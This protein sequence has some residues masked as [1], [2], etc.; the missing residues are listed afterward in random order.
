[1]IISSRLSEANF[2]SLVLDIVETFLLDMLTEEVFEND[3]EFINN[4]IK[5][6][7][8]SVQSPKTD[9]VKIHDSFRKAISKIKTEDENIEDLKEFGKTGL[10]FKDSKIIINFINENIKSVKEYIENQSIDSF[11]GI[12]IKLI[13]EKHLNALDDYKFS[14]LVSET[15]SWNQYQNIILA[16]MNNKHIEEIK[17]IW[18]TEITSD[19]DNFYILLAKGFYYLLPWI[20]S[21]LILLTA[22]I[23][24][25]D[26]FEISENIR[27]IPT[28]M[29]YGLNN[30]VACIARGCGIKT[31]ETAL[32]LAKQ[33]NKT[34]HIEF[35]SWLANLQKQ[36]I[37]VM[38]LSSFEKENIIDIV[39]S[40]AP[41]SNKND[42]THFSFDIVGTKYK[43][44]WKKTSLHIRNSDTLE[45][46]RDKENKY[47][48]F[49]IL[50][51]KNNNAIGYVPRE[52]S[53]YIATEMDLNNSYYIVK[54]SEIKS[55]LESDYNIISVNVELLVF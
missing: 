10:D 22:Y 1:M 21:A 2:D 42:P 37:D 47:D 51:T 8:F 25:I 34:S 27:Y 30:K 15:T 18:E 48:P 28:F 38:P 43:D 23:L 33:S 52:Y 3:E 54:V 26:Y 45:L 6:S 19:F 29:K 7:L 12:F 5:N 16:W 4:I 55:Q 41:N 49:A 35:I 13:T 39:F 17:N 50:V 9:I 11:I 32:F 36:E 53:K 20:C 40:I 46:Q 44:S 31:R 24:K 14:K